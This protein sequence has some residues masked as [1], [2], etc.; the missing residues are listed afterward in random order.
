MLRRRAVAP[1]LLAWLGCGL[2][3]LLVLIVPLEEPLSVFGV[4]L[5][6]AGGMQVL[7]RQIV[8]DQRSRAAIGF[9]FLSGSLFFAV[10]WVTQPGRSYT[11]LGVIILALLTGALT[12]EPFLFAAVF[13]ELAAMASILML[14]PPGSPGYERIL[15]LLILYTLA[16][17]GIL[18]TGWLLENVGVTSVTPELAE[19]VM[20]FLAFGFSILMF[21]P[22]FH[23]WLPSASISVK[24]P[25][26]AFVALTL[27]SAGLFTLLRFLDTYAWLRA[28]PRLGNAIGIAGAIMV[29]FG[30]F[31]A[32]AHRSIYRV[33]AYALLAD[34]GVGLLAISS[35]REVGYRLALYLAAARLSGLVLYS[36]ASA[37]LFSDESQTGTAST[38]ARAGALVGLASLAGVPLTAG[39]PARWSAVAELGLGAVGL[40]IPIGSV[41]VMVAVVRIGMRLP[42]PTSDGPRLRLS[43]Q[44]AIGSSMA[45]CLLLGV[46]PQLAGPWVEAAMRGLA[47]L[48]P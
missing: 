23:Y 6:V 2:I 24:P 10:S 44:V 3:G 13:L 38:L 30:S 31:S 1:H 27:Q 33:S 40:W 14:V 46:A 8:I 20:I 43:E 36:L 4:P 15:Q 22:P 47:N 16:M 19:R 39:F 28:D 32:M 34:F 21:V 48:T 11:P 12:I 35:D 41:L 45:L 37:R 25:A 42:A 5:R 17:V 18:F 26:L 7:G 29:G 9:L